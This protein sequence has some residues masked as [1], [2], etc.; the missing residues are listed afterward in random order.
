MI[1]SWHTRLLTIRINLLIRDKDSGEIASNEFDIWECE[2]V[3]I[4]VVSY[5]LSRC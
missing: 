2:Y 3:W 4:E 5:D 1:A